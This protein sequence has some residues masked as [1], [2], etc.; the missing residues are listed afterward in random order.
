MQYKNDRARN[1]GAVKECG[2]G[3]QIMAGGGG[4]GAA[5]CSAV[6]CLEERTSEGLCIRRHGFGN[7]FK[8]DLP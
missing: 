8:A 4:C 1:V 6:Q 2:E 5:Q 3:R 7:A